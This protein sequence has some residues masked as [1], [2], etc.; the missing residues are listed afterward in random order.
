MMKLL[1]VTSIFALFASG[2]HGRMVSARMLEKKVDA[3]KKFSAGYDVDAMKI[4]SAGYD[5]ALEDYGLAHLPDL[6]K[7]D[8][9]SQRMPFCD[10]DAVL[11]SGS[12][13]GLAPSSTVVVIRDKHDNENISSGPTQ[14]VGNTH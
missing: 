14:R 7:T 3:M 11:G 1:V 6:E 4:F 2:V 10:V 8:D 5:A 13:T 12:K 9:S